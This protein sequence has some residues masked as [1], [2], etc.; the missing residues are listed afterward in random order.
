MSPH[1]LDGVGLDAGVLLARYVQGPRGWVIQSQSPGVVASAELV[2]AL[3]AGA[4][5]VDC[6]DTWADDRWDNEETTVG[7][8]YLVPVRL[9]GGRRAILGLFGPEP[10]ALCPAAR[11]LARLLAQSWA[12]IENMTVAGLPWAP[13]Q[14][15]P[16]TSAVDEAYQQL[17]VREQDVARLL[18][19]GHRVRTAA[20]ALGLSEHTVRNHLKAI[21]RKLGVHSQVELLDALR[22]GHGAR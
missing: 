17:S 18:V 10:R 20:R 7:A 11:S 21:F 6:A 19:A 3:A 14:D 2:G 1:P 5:P 16:T 13:P 12:H 4:G 22:F 9:S 15:A 8:A